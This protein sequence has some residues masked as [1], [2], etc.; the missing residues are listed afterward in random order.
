ML[1]SIRQRTIAR[2]AWAMAWFGLVA[3]Q[4]HALA[5]HNTVDGKSDLELPLTRLWSDP[6]RSA[7]RPLLDWANPDA[8]Y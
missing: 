8:V 3:G 5:R 7:L 1:E 2:Y 4:L 6:A